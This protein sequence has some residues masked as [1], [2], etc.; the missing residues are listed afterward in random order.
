MNITLPIAMYIKKTEVAKD[1]TLLSR[2]V[3]FKNTKRE[4]IN[5]NTNATAPINKTVII[6]PAF[7]MLM[8]FK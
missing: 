1:T 8:L 7:Y 4:M 5:D 2:V 6:S 3:A